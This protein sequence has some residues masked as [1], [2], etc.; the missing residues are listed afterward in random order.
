MSRYSVSYGL[1]S[2]CCTELV[3]GV[4]QRE[5]V[6]GFPAVLLLS[7]LTS[8][9]HLPWLLKMATVF[10]PASTSAVLLDIEGTTTPITFVK[11]NHNSPP[12]GSCFVSS[13]QWLSTNYANNSL[14]P[15]SSVVWLL[16]FPA[17]MSNI[18]TAFPLSFCILFVW[19]VDSSLY[20]FMQPIMEKPQYRITIWRVQMTMGNVGKISL[21]FPTVRS[22]SV[23]VCA[24]ILLI[25]DAKSTP[26]T[27]YSKNIV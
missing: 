11:V 8:A 25:T 22:V 17:V 27:R 21:I 26:D 12:I 19:C 6:F 14:L 4:S 10:I 23:Y 9:N 7:K 1:D 3:R 16:W 5:A 20:Y 15:R 13:L 24:L 18:N 2:I